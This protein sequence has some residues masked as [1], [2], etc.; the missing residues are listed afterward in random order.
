MRCPE[1]PAAQEAGA[2]ARNSP[3][4][5]DQSQAGDDPSCP[6]RDPASERASPLGAQHSR[7]PGSTTSSPQ[8]LFR[9][10]FCRRGRPARPPHFPSLPQKP[11]KPPSRPQLRGE[12]PGRRARYWACSGWSR[13][14]A[15]AS[16]VPSASRMGGFD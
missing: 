3:P 12:A 9:L 7:S 1:S 6:A 11:R 8:R 4:G 2:G 15:G 10:C 16:G 5:S 14:L 13:M